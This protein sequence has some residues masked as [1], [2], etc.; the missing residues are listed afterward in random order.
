VSAVFLAALALA[1]AAPARAGAYRHPA[2]WI[3]D[4]SCLADKRFTPAQ[5]KRALDAA[6]RKMSPDVP[7]A[8]GGCLSE[9]NPAWA[10]ELAGFVKAKTVL[11][12]CPA[13]DETSRT[14]ASHEKTDD[15]TGGVVRLRNVAA[16]LAEGGTGLAGVLFHETLHA[17]GADNFPLEKHNKAGELPQYEFVSDRVYGTEALCFLGVEPA[18]RKQV[19]LLQCR[20]AVNYMADGSPRH[21]CEGFNLSFYDTVPGFLKH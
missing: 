14:C 16:C 20:A 9:Y 12:I 18:T 2:G 3:V 8:Q 7:V 4:E 1:A 5:F 13:Y 17:D 11:I 15:G 6:A 10:R 21:R 19:N